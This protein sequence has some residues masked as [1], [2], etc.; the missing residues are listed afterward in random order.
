[1]IFKKAQ[2]EAGIILSILVFQAFIIVFLGFINIT[3]PYDTED[4]GGEI[5]IVGIPLTSWGSTLINNI[6][7]L[8]WA[9]AIIFAPATLCL[10]YIIVR[11]FR[12]GG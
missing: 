8:G 9:N 1:M 2:S 10:T 4:V 12:G 5:S 7:V 6:S 11:L 3:I